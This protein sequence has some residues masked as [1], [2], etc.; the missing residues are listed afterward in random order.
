MSVM[1]YSKLGEL[2]G[3]PNAIMARTICSQSLHGG[4]SRGVEPVQRLDGEETITHPRVPSPFIEGDE[5]V[6]SAWKHAEATVKFRCDNKLMDV[7]AAAA[8][9]AV[10]DGDDLG[11]SYTSVTPTVR[12]GAYT[13]ISRK[14]FAIADNLDGAIDEAGRRS[15]VA[16]QLAKQGKPMPPFG[17]IH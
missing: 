10:L 5:I 8:S 3:T 6:R 9:N 2:Q 13:Q 7:L 16:Y 11:T 17:E 12:L 1:A 4:E 15:E 14:D